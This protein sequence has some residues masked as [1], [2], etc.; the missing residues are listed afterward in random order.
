MLCMFLF[1]TF[2]AYAAT[3]TYLSAS[4][5]AID[6]STPDTIYAGT[7]SGVFKSTN[8]GDS[9]TQVSTGLTDLP[10]ASLAIDPSTPNTIYAQTWAGGVFKSSNGG[11]SWTQVSTEFTFK[12]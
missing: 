1:S 5:L 9:W 8:A 7:G 10:I 6:P 11:D 12:K 2:I 4:Y 3:L